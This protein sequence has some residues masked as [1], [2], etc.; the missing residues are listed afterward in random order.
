MLNDTEI[1]EI[2]N[3][4]I[5]AVVGCSPKEDRPSFRVSS[6]LK[7]VGYKIIPVR[8]GYETILGE[9]CYPNLFEFLSSFL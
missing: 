2:L 5:I 6:Y 1:R 4:K 7:S 9:K 8:P 3:F